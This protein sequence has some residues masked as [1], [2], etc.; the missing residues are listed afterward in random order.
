MARRFDERVKQ[1]KLLWMAAGHSLGVP[2]DRKEEAA[3]ALDRFDNPIG[4]NGAD[5]KIGRQI[6][7]D[8]VV[9]ARYRHLAGA[10]DMGET[11]ARRDGNLVSW[12][13]APFARAHVSRVGPGT[14]GEVLVKA[15]AQ[16]HIEDLQ[17]AAYP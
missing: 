4:G 8:L 17:P 3:R 5:G 15:A 14:I 6:P 16:R 13:A 12:L 9:G 10:D 11:G 2:L 7:D 1:G